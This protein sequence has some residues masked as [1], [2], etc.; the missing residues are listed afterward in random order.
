[1]KFLMLVLMYATNKQLNKMNY[2]EYFKF[3]TM[4]Y[5]NLCMKNVEF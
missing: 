5:D 4:I 2:D 3:K 1:M